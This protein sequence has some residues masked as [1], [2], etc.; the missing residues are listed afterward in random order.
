[1]ISVNKRIIY[2]ILYTICILVPY[3]N[4]YELT[5][6]IWFI[7]L[8][9]TIVNKYSL[10][11]LKY[12]SCFIIILL[13]AFIVSFFKDEST[14][15][16]FRDIAYLLKPILGLL[17]GYQ[18][19]KQN[20][21][22][23]FPTVIYTGLIISIAHLIIIFI[24][25]L[26]FYTISVNLLRDFCGFH[27]DYEVYVLIILIFHKKF[28]L[29]W[30]MKKIYLMIIIVGLSS[31]L[32]LSRTNFIQIVILYIALRGYF[33]INKK[34]IVIMS[35]VL[36]LVTGSYA[37][38]YHSNPQR[39][40]KGIE[41]FLYKIKNA[42]I[43]PFKTKINKENWKDFNDNYRSYENI[44]TVKQ[45]SSEG[46]LA[47]IFGRGLGVTID[48]G[49]QIMTN[50]HELIQYIPILHNGF[51]TVYLKSGLLG[52]FFLLLFLY[53]I[54]KPKKST[55]TQVQNINL[56]MLGTAIFLIIS[57]WVFMGVYLKLDNKSVL[58]GFLICF[59]EI[60]IKKDKIEFFKKNNE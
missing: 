20:P 30:S 54:S 41:E 24:T 26:R 11:V 13:I 34:S 49:R 3:I 7:T 46:I 17:I 39:S 29:S 55:L 33:I 48:L 36:L 23:F 59:R 58:I 37:I 25:F 35:Y 19:Y 31:F 14:Y 16:F 38:I 43:E 51:A 60:I 56:L 18:L 10:E 27:S 32:Y 50:D 40:G 2:S 9:L 42:P 57:N 44:L 52:L 12:I 5:F 4:N 21:N 53:L 28:E 8:C 15:N 22:N 45:V 47:I 1:M 6:S